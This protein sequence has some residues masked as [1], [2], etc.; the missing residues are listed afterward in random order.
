MRISLALAAFNAYDELAKLGLY[1]S[2][3]GK[4]SPDIRAKEN[5]SY[6]LVQP[7]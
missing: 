1:S 5:I 3:A 2:L 4:K 6:E 7:L